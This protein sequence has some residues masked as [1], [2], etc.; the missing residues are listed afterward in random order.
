MKK[1]GTGG[2]ECLKVS[3]WPNNS[4]PGYKVKYY[5]L[6]LP[7]CSIDISMRSPAVKIPCKL[8]AVYCMEVSPHTSSYSTTNF[9]CK[10]IELIYWS[11]EGIM[12]G[13]IDLIGQVL[14]GIMLT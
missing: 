13:S 6:P 3:I 4:L 8:C 14:R 2:K 7:Y 1:S 12:L 9:V 10:L 11:L 5:I